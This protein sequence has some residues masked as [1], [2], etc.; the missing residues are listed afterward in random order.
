MAEAKKLSLADILAKRKEFEDMVAAQL[1]SE[2]PA[3]L[4][5]VLER[6]VDPRF[7]TAV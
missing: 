7:E 4:A 3:A 1:Q 2:R 5:S 6:I